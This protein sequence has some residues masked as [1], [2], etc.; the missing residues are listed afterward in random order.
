MTY[1]GRSKTSM[2]KI[3]ANT[4]VKEDGDTGVE[5]SASLDG[6]GLQIASETLA[7][8][9]GLMSNLKDADRGLH[10]AVIGALAGDLSILTGEESEKDYEKEMAELT[11]RHSMIGK[12][13]LN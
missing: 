9:Q 1:R 2:V 10:A 3:E 7:A 8:I 5:I 11:S 4:I 6:H 12:G 13:G